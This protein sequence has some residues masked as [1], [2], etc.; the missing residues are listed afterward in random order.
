MKLQLNNVHLVGYLIG[1]AGKTRREIAAKT[2]TT[3]TITRISIEIE[4]SFYAVR[5]AENW[6]LDI[7]SEHS[8]Q[9]DLTNEQAGLILGPGGQDIKDIRSESRASIGIAKVGCRNACS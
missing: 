8:F 7:I 3:V 5:E 6:I 9:V 1:E 4:G 2:G